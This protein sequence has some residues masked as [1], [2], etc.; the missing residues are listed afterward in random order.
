MVED[1]PAC[2]EKRVHTAEEWRDYHPLAG[3]GYS[4]GQGWTRPDLD[5]G[6]IMEHAAPAK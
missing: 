3:H 4:E 1:C 2:I 6:R 5:P